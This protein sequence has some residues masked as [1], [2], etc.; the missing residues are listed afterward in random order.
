MQKI[1][2]GSRGSQLALAQTNE[3]ASQLRKLCPNTQISIKI[4]KTKGD[5]IIDVPLAKIGGKGLFIK[6]LEEALLR[7]EID[8]AVHSMKDVPTELHPELMIAAI[9]KRLDVRDVLISKDDLLLDKL[10]A[11][12]I[13]GTSSLRRKV[14][15]VHY[16]TDLK[17]ID[18]RGNLDTRVKKLEGQELDGIVVAAAGCIRANLSHKITQFLPTKILLPA[19]GQG[20]LGIEIRKDN[21]KI[22]EI[23][24]NLND[25]ES[26]ITIS[27]ERAFIKR[28]GGSCQIPAAALACIEGDILRLEGMIAILDEQKIIRKHIEGKKEAAIK[29]GEELASRI[30]VNK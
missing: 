4:I 23:I 9:T 24:A 11:K 27:A 7:K 15:L 17:V 12:A 8:I 5:K 28:L 20:S 2:I 14:Q 21:L 6:E 22:K 29:L 13:I 10:P 19:A 30:K 26:Y 3:I 16:R 18:L 1:I 25:D